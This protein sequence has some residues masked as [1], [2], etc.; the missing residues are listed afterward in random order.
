MILKAYLVILSF[1]LL[2]AIIMLFIARGKDQAESRKLWIWYSVYF[3]V[4]NILFACTAFNPSLFHYLSILIIFA[5]YLELIKLFTY[6]GFSFRGFFIISIFIY[7]L[8]AGCFYFFG[9]LKME[10]ILYTLLIVSVFDAFSR[11][12]GQLFIKRSLL[13]EVSPGKTFEGIAC[14][15][16]CALAA[17]AFLKDLPG[18]T[19]WVSFLYTLGII[20][21]AFTG[22]LAASWYRKQFKAREF[23][24]TLP[25]LGGI[26]D[27]FCSL[28]AAGT[29]MY[30]LM[31]FHF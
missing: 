5:G 12:T 21:S 29:F 10:L 13:P 4:F 31:K 20:A 17:S 18:I 27:C 16:L 15:A 23:S 14:G 28:I 2:G 30:L 24:K 19:V 8:L 9:Q 1:F 6:S 25:G 7:S 3:L 11:V 22:D 26:L